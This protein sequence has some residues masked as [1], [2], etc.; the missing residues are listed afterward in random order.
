MH[1]AMSTE[2]RLQPFLEQY[3]LLESF[4]TQYP[5]RED[6]IVQLCG[7]F[8]HPQQHVSPI[9][10][11]GQTATGKTSVVNGLLQ[12]LGLPHAF[13]SC[14]DCYVPRLLFEHILDQICDTNLKGRER[15]AACKCM[16]PRDFLAK[17]THSD[18]FCD[19]QT[20]TYLVVDGA[21][22]LSRFGE[23]TQLLYLF[24]RLNELT[25]KKVTPIFISQCHWR[26]F[27]SC[28]EALAPSP[29][30]VHFPN[31]TKEEVLRVI[32]LPGRPRVSLP[33]KNRPAKKRKDKASTSCRD[34]DKSGDTND[35]V[36]FRKF[37][38]IAYD[39]LSGVTRDFIEIRSHIYRLYPRYASPVEKGEETRTSSVKLWNRIKPQ[40][41]D[42][43][44]SL[45]KPVYTPDDNAMKPD[46]TATG[47][48]SNSAA[49][50]PGVK[51][52]ASAMSSS[53]EPNAQEQG[54]ASKKAK[55]LMEL[56]RSSK[57]L[58]LAAYLASHTSPQLDVR[59]FSTHNLKKR[60]RKQT[61]SKKKA[62]SVDKSIDAGPRSFPLERMLAIFF[63][64]Q[65]SKSTNDVELDEQIGSLRTLRLVSPVNTQQT[66]LDG[67]RLKCHVSWDTALLISRTL[68]F[69]L[70]DYFDRQVVGKSE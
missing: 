61:N 34:N 49:V 17:L 27:S 8:G 5:G 26:D 25:R 35:D 18:T 19:A 50:S 41:D 29:Y 40:V 51:R 47:E 22:C 62:S 39:V 52:K 68:A 56:P 48:P 69:E 55:L 42:A 10:I 64:I 37:A 60:L 13:V 20:T 23:G 7:L 1:P 30:P 33:A 4:L 12:A 31:Y 28:N 36:L 53:T 43:L 67:M 44:Q 9:S 16:R 2:A 57:Y 63:S 24:L 14:I 3:P 54:R 58:I 59:Y 38:E 6:Q 15:T 11:S 21:E 65:E 70:V 32:S 45:Y 46:G 66:Q